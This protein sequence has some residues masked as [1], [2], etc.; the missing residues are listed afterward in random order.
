M[1]GL[2]RVRFPNTIP[3]GA[4]LRG[5]ISLMSYEAIPGGAR[6]TL[7]VV[8]E[9]RNEEKPACVAEFITQAYTKESSE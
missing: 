9:M 5:R 3:S 1:Y 8:F 6:F 2:D 7:K 4:R